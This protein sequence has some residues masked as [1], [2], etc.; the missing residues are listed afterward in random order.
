MDRGRGFAFLSALALLLVAVPAEAQESRS[1]K[2][3]R[4]GSKWVDPKSGEAKR[5]ILDE[6][7]FETDTA[8]VADAQ[9]TLLCAAECAKQDGSIYYVIE[10]Y[11]DGRGTAA[12]NQKLSEARAR[13]VMDYLAFLGV[14]QDRMKA[15]GMG[16]AGPSSDRVT[17][18]VNRKV[19]VIPVRGGFEG[20]V[21]T[22]LPVSAIPCGER[23][24]TRY[25]NGETVPGAKIEI[26]GQTFLISVNY[27]KIR[28]DLRKEIRAAMATQPAPVAPVASEPKAAGAGAPQGDST[29][30]PARSVDTPGNEGILEVFAVGTSLDTE[31]TL[32]RVMGG[33][34]IRF[35]ET[36]GMQIGFQGQFGQYRRRLQADLGFTLKQGVFKGAIFGSYGNLSGV[37]VEGPTP[38]NLVVA[39]GGAR[40]GLEWPAFGAGLS[41]TTSSAPGTDPDPA[42][43]PQDGATVTLLD[44]RW[45]PGSFE[46]RFWGGSARKQDA[47]LQDF[48]MAGKAFGGMELSYRFG[49]SFS[50]VLQAETL[51][52]YKVYTTDGKAE[53]RV[54]LGIRLGGGKRGAAPMW[55]TAPSA[56]TVFPI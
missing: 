2:V 24:T 48:E 47:N 25:D 12:H 23:V 44:L 20:E 18:F 7:N 26:N 3:V 19:L 5:T 6:V 45:T 52:I 31:K 30:A 39:M 40:I 27:A 49:E 33:Y 10:G 21:I 53:N 15:V 36:G 41:F 54:S 14:P 29:P 4:G 9:P 55:V 1:G 22:K 13:A 37:P 34:L 11:T 46:A 50:V 17:N 43:L 35:G 16:K 42:A 28:A 8:V 56:R 38:K 51:P 32:G